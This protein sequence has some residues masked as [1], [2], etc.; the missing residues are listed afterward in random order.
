MPNGDR[1]VIFFHSPFTHNIFLYAQV[2]FAIHFVSNLGN[3]F[4]EGL[5]LFCH[6]MFVTIS[7]LVVA[8]ASTDRAFNLQ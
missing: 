2:V 5:S 8:I 1:R 4:H 6:V 3:W 7:Q